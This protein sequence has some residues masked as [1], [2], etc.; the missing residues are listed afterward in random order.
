M[1]QGTAPSLD[2][3]TI[4]RRLAEPA[5]FLALLHEIQD[6]FGW[7]PEPAL[8]QV[9]DALGLPIAEVFSS[10]SFYHYFRLQP[11]GPIE[12]RPCDGP[13]CALRGAG[14]DG[15]SCPGRCDL[16]G[17]RLVGD[18]LEPFATP[19]PPTTEAAEFFF[20]YVREGRPGLADYRARGGY[21]GSPP[22]PIERL[23]A[24]GLSGRGGAGFPAAL[25]WRAVRAAAGSPKAVICNA[26]EGEPGCFKDRV[27]LDHDPHAILDGMLHAGRA[28]GASFGLIYLRYEYPQS[29][30]V[31]ER[32][33]AEAREAGLLDGFPIH[34]RRGAGAYICG[35]ETALLNSLEGKRPFPRERPPYPTERGLFGR[36]TL[37]HN[38]E[39][40]AALPWILGRD[41]DVPTRLFSV[42]GDVDRPGTYELPA[43]TRLGELLRRA[44]GRRPKAASLAG[45]SGGFAGGAELEAMPATAGTIVYGEGRCMVRAAA[46]AMRF[47]ARESCGKCFPCRIGTTRLV[48][49]LEAPTPEGAS[50]IERVMSPASACGLGTS[51][52]SITRS[53]ARHWPAELEAHQRGVCLAK[54]CG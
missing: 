48:E 10:A 35:E 33:I 24:S 30:P 13:A 18:R 2:V 42:S 50:R 15:I 19:L 23:R 4:R 29:I 47:F 25:K 34:V 9:A 54:E 51:A 36:P 45:L 28:V 44:G 32:A 6:R 14:S 41:V 3:E 8:D 37:V 12:P 16:E 43:D 31:L 40:L 52:P 27:L 22:D 17:P 53:L 49:Y 46:V 21:R 11:P 38:V 7:L 5:P 1:I 20:R 39:T 26:D